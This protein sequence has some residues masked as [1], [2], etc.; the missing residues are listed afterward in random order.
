MPCIFG[1]A[2]R[3]SL[4]DTHLPFMLG[5]WVCK[6]AMPGHR[7]RAIT[8]RLPGPCLHVQIKG[9]AVGFLAP[10]FRSQSTLVAAGLCCP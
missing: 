10:G 3:S 9:D 5:S 1:R 8:A 6:L 7:V 2:L 4:K